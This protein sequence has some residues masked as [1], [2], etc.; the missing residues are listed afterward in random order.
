MGSRTR[1]G[2]RWRTPHP[3]KWEEKRTERTYRGSCHCG[4]VKFEAR[5]DL[6]GGDGKYCTFGTKTRS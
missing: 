5:M 1:S 6:A 3:T 2:A 4:A